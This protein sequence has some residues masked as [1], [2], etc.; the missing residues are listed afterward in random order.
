VSLHRWRKLAHTT[1]RDVDRVGH[2]IRR[3]AATM[4]NAIDNTI[5][6][7]WPNIEPVQRA[8]LISLV[9]SNVVFATTESGSG[10][11]ATAL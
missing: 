3:L 2:E 5:D 11:T 8:G 9:R 6:N 10:K 1:G 4:E 7:S